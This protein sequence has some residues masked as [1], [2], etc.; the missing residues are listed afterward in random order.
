MTSKNSITGDSL[1]NKVGS[2]EQKRKFDENFDTI[3]RPSLDKLKKLTIIDKEDPYWKKYFEGKD[4]D[5][6]TR[7]D[8]FNLWAC[9]SL[10]YIRSFVGWI[11]KQIPVYLDEEI[12]KLQKRIADLESIINGFT[13]AGISSKSK[14]QPKNVYNINYKVIIYSNGGGSGGTGKME[15]EDD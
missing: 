7:G 11:M 5:W 3:F 6:D 4:D 1:I 13:K 8:S 14:Q 15:V 12:P 2:K 10:F 9:I